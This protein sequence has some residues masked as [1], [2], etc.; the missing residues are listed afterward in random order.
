MSTRAQRS[1]PKR[2]GVKAQAEGQ[3]GLDSA[4]PGRV[5]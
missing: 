1:L 3:G 2:D 5:C 4:S